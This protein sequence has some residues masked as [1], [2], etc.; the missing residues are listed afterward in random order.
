V[1][2]VKTDINAPGTRL[3]L[4]SVSAVQKNQKFRLYSPE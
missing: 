1:S 2:V 4:N 3:L